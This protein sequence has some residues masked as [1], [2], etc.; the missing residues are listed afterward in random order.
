MR[1]LLRSIPLVA[2]V[3]LPCLVQAQTTRTT[4]LEQFT[5]TWCQWCPYGADTINVLLQ[6][7]PNARAV[8]HHTGNNEPMSTAET[9]TIAQHLL[10]NSWPSGAIDRLLVNL[11]TGGAAIAI[12]RTYWRQVLTSRAQS[13]APLSIAVAG[14]WNPDNRELAFTVTMNI[15]QDMQGEFYLNAHLNEDSLNYAQLKN[16]SGSVISLNP[17]YHRRVTRKMISGVYGTTLTTT[18]FTNGQVVTQQ[19]TYSVPANYN[20]ANCRLTVFL[21]T[22]VTLNVN[23]QPRAFNMAVQQAWQEPVLNVM[24]VT[25]VELVSFHGAQVNDGVRLE[26]RTAT[27]SNNRGWFI[28]RRENE[29]SWND[30]GFVDGRGTTHEQQ[31]Y[32]YFDSGVRSGNTYDYRLR[33]VDFDG[34]IER[35][36]IM[37]VMVAPTPTATRMLPNYPN[38]FNPS[39]TI[40]V[41]LAEQSDVN[42]TIYDML[43]RHIRTLV[44]GVREAGGHMFEWDGTDANGNPVE[45]GMYFA[46]MITPTHTATQQMQLSK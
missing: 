12:S 9:E 34:T 4:L 29:G 32:E 16:V 44:S 27:E 35:S 20:I 43:G 25:P 41:E 46:R 2:L 18:G 7:I 5:G 42:V 8:A 10:V 31:Q 39:T 19:Y 3:L 22:K 37:R 45:S 6:Q 38:P 14:T 17:Y 15:L 11:P 1:T 28:E 26:W 13:T 24:S 21:T 23:N 33:Q 30:L 36:D 40:V